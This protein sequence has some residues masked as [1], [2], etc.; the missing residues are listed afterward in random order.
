MGTV[1]MVEV[2][3]TLMVMKTMP[4]NMMKEREITMDILM[5]RRKKSNQ[6]VATR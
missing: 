2:M 5:V 4:M 6:R 3:D 1:M